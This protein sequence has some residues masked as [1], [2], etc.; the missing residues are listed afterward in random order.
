MNRLSLLSLK[1]A[2]CGT[3]AVAVGQQDAA[4]PSN[5][6]TPA[7]PSA[8]PAK[9]ANK[10]SARAAAP[11]VELPKPTMADVAYGKHPKQVLH[12]WKAESEKP[13][14]LVFFIHGGGWQNGNRSSGLA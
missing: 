11:K 13:A 5:P 2:L 4:A 6:E 9:A 7:K 14:P 3:I 8:E 10:R 12:F 1:L